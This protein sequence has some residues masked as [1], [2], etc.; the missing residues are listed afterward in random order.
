MTLLTLSPSD[1]VAITLI[2]HPGGAPAGHKVALHAVAAGALIRKYG[3]V[4]GQASCDIEAGTWVHTHNLAMSTSAPS[5]GP[6]TRARP[7]STVR[8]PATWSGYRRANGR[9]GTRNTIAILTSVNCSATVARRIAG[10]FPP[11]TLPAGVDDVV[12]YT[13]TGGCGG[14]SDSQDVTLLQRTLAGYARNPNVAAVLIVGLGCEANQIPDWL[15]RE[16]LTAGPDLRTLSIQEAGG[17]LKAIDAG[18]AIVRQLIAE[19]ANARREPAPL[20][21]LVVGLQCGGSDSWSGVTANPALGRAVDRLIALG[22]SALLSETP[23]IWGAEQLL[24]KRADAETA[25]ALM[26]R[27]AWWQD[28]ALHNGM[29]MNNNPSPGNLKGGLTT[30]LEKSLGAVAKAGSAPLVDVIGYAQPVR[31]AGLSFMD[32]PG[33]DPCSATGQIASGANLIAFTTGRG[34]VFGSRP[35]PCLKI[36]S[37]ARLADWMAEDIDVD[38]SGVLNGESLD[39]VGETIFQRLLSLASGEPSA[40]EILGIGDAEFVPWQRGAYL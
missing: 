26:E 12:A 16:G 28:Y 13:H 7:S 9:W 19:A 32:S 31:K 27:L 18:Q 33:Y 3:Q 17:T 20:S 2:D 8:T 23:E 38:A 30:I 34:S 37:N 39:S 21:G 36:A 40:S 24:L 4:I 1:D 22:G 5:S 15:E 29:E 35:A 14:A 11:D 6:E 25:R 10:A